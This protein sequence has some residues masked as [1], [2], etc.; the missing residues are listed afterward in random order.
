MYKQLILNISNSNFDSNVSR[1]NQ[2]AELDPF[3]S[4][5]EKRHARVKTWTKNIDLFKK[6]FVVVPINE[7][8][9]W[10]LAIICFPG[11][12]G[13]QT[14]EGNPI[15]IEITPKKKSELLS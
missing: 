10:F 2:P 13:C 15:K 12:D 5:A 14:F 1:K 9:H 4:P 3:L 7:N 6:D 11:L 8:C